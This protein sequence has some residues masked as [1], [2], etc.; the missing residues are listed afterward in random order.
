MDINPALSATDNIL[1]LVTDPALGCPVSKDDLGV[2]TPWV[3]EPGAAGTVHGRNVDGENSNTSVVVFLRPDVED[4]TEDG[5]NQTI[6]Y[7]RQ[8]LAALLG[9][10]PAAV[11]VPNNA[12]DVEVLTAIASQL[13]LIA[14]ELIVQTPITNAQATVAVSTSSTPSLVYL[15]STVSVNLTWTT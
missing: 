2:T 14:S 4:L 9:A 11:S 1:A 8:T 12:T 5:V 13:G 6:I 3:Y 15:P 10:N 7:E